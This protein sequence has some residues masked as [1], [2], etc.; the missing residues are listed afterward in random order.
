MKQTF[1]FLISLSLFIVTSSCPD[2][3]DCDDITVDG[4]MYCTGIQGKYPF[5]GINENVTILY[6]DKSKAGPILLKNQVC[7]KAFITKKSLI[8]C[9]TAHLSQWK[10]KSFILNY[11]DLFKKVSCI[12][13]DTI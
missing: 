7:A 2:N 4:Y 9:Q 13:I 1:I 10:K 5:D 6:V 3:C 12:V 11:F 8:F